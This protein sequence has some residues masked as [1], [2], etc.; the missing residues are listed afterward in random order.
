M[1]Q[2]TIEARQGNE[3]GYPLAPLKETQPYQH[4]HFSLRPTSDF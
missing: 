2:G 3:M 4:L 1:S